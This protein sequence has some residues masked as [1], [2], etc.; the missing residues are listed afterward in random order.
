MYYKEM[1]RISVEQLEELMPLIPFGEVIEE[2]AI[3]PPELRGEDYLN[4]L[5]KIQLG[6]QKTRNDDLG[7]L[8]SAQRF[9]AND[10]VSGLMYQRIMKGNIME[11]M[12]NSSK[13]TRTDRRHNTLI[14]MTRNTIL[15][16]SI[17][18]DV[19]SIEDSFHN[20]KYPENIL[21]ELS[22]KPDKSYRNNNDS[23]ILISD[24]S[25][26]QR[27]QAKRDRKSTQKEYAN[28]P[29][30]KEIF[31]NPKDYSGS[32]IS[33]TL[34]NQV[35]ESTRK[36]TT[37][38]I[39]NNSLSGFPKNTSQYQNNSEI[40]ESLM[41]KNL[42]R[43]SDAEES[44]LIDESMLN[45]SGNDSA[46]RNS[47]FKKPTSKKNNIFHSS[48]PPPDASYLG[49]GILGVPDLDNLTPG[50]FDKFID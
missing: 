3:I 31:A 36:T 6:A 17:N 28:S 12:L 45:K 35:R 13:E 19:N 32:I 46:I 21:Q 33:D 2:R 42:S 1:R 8:Q 39:I 20:S 16:R 5:R 27:S 9:M 30:K 34:A 47:T 11:N 23:A 24:A 48:Q 25:L 40:P 44:K 38:P 10:P 41:Y 22:L 18:Q 43:I 50:L 29:S 7:E 15:P 14:N 49:N 37:K 26:Y 4:Y